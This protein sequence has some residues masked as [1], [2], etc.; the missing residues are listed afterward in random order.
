MG[1][2]QTPGHA[3]CALDIPPPAT[4]LVLPSSLCGG[5]ED[6]SPPHA[7]PTP[8]DSYFY[9]PTL[10]PVTMEQAPLSHSVPS[11]VTHSAVLS[12]ALPAEVPFHILRGQEVA[13]TAG[14]RVTW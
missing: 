6:R 1:G 3:E 8:S 7:R 11:R 9:R 13:E 14:R 10:A 5:S 12:C 4:S 2:P